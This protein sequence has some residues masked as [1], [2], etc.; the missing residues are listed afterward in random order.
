MILE[1]KK[2]GFLEANQQLISQGVISLIHKNSYKAISRNFVMDLLTHYEQ[3]SYFKQFT[4]KASGTTLT[5]LPRKE[6][7]DSPGQI[8]NKV[9]HLE[10][11]KTTSREEEAGRAHGH[12]SVACLS[13]PFCLHHTSLEGLPSR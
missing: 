9:S 11:A 2:P 8:P 6:A 5:V 12:E 13:A 3:T 7:T 1:G 4:G 10:T